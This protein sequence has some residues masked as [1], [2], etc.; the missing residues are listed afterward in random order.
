MQI[1]YLTGTGK[2][3]GTGEVEGT[4]GWMGNEGRLVSGLPGGEVPLVS[5]LGLASSLGRKLLLL[6][7]SSQE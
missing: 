6:M 5:G 4:R 1:L 2:V 3:E 7:S